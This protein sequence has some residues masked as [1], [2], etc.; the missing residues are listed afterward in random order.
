[1]DGPQRTHWDGCWRTHGHSEC[2]KAKVEALEA[3]LA[4]TKERLI[5]AEVIAAQTSKIDDERQAIKL[6]LRECEAD[7]ATAT[8][9]LVRQVQDERVRAEKAE[10]IIAQHN[11]CHD[12]HGKVGAREFSEGC[13]EEQRKIYGHAPLADCLVELEKRVDLLEKRCSNPYPPKF[14][15]VR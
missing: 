2:A 1:M 8:T 15:E 7:S 6:R 11:L 13:I 5:C 10:A 14:G 4:A 12:L 3:Q 9:E